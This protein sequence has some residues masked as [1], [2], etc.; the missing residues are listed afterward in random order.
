MSPEPPREPTN[1]LAGFFK[2]HMS[3]R[4][5]VPITKATKTKKNTLQIE[6][7]ASDPSID[8]DLE[9]FSAEAVVKMSEDVNNGGI[10]IKV[11]HERKFYTEIGVWKSAEMV[12]DKMHVVGEIDLDLSLGRDL[13]ILLNKGVE[14]G[15][16]VGGTV[17]GVAQEFVKDLGRYIN[18]YTD[19]ILNEISVVRNPS[20][21]SA[22]G[23]AISKSFEKSDSGIVQQGEAEVGEKLAEAD[24]IKKSGGLLYLAKS[25]GG[26]A[27]K[28]FEEVSKEIDSILK[29]SDYEDSPYNGVSSSD[30][31]SMVMI[32]KVL[33]TID[34]ETVKKPAEFEDLYEFTKDLPDESFIPFLGYREF[35]HHNKDFTLNIDYVKYWLAQIANGND[36]YLT[37]KEFNT[38]VTHLYQHLKQ[39]MSENGGGMEKKETSVEEVSDKPLDEATLNLMKQC[40]NFKMFSIGNRPQVDGNDLS[41]KEI[42]KVANAFAIL[43]ARSASKVTVA[44]KILASYVQEEKETEAVEKS[45]SISNPMPEEKKEQEAQQAEET[46]QKTSD[47]TEESVKTEEEVSADASENKTGDTDSEEVA[48]KSEAEEEEEKSSEAEPDDEKEAEKSAEVEE[49]ESEEEK[50]DEEAEKSLSKEE[51]TEIA[52]SVVTDVIS[53]EVMPALAELTKS[54]KGVQETL[55]KSQASVKKSADA[56]AQKTSSLE[57][58]VKEQGEL[59]EKS[60]KLISA[61]GEK[62]AP[63]KSMAFAMLEKTFSK[64]SASASDKEGVT[65][66]ELMK[67]YMDEDNLSFTEAYAKARREVEA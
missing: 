63:R 15:L 56:E 7:V 53:S 42:S 26:E 37:Q 59:L 31:N 8:R 14:I 43:Q 23:L 20:N 34:L 5:N 45:S 66:E 17:L 29:Y 40:Y 44:S 36:M 51:V 32:V 11:E 62:A 54:L 1:T 60:I 58:T 4:L 35:P 49:K 57:K 65:Q 33:Q 67:K 19:V 55:E 18:V 24:F 12:G 41:D 64:G 22:E 48:E 47:A 25:V 16:S 46:A 39:F 28:S 21:Y 30:F 38:S 2:N 13:E 27:K 6:G 52:K 50:H 10:P 9:R 61:I 3:F